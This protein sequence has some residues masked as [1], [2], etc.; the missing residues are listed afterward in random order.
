M[1]AQAAPF[2]L[3]IIDRDREGHC[4]LVLIP[5][6]AAKLEVVGF[7][8]ERTRILFFPLAFHASADL[9]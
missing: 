6:P 7:A 8:F 4:M 1:D 3:Q 2:R 5:L 9:A